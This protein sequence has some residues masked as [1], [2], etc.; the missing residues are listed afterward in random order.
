MKST[1]AFLKRD[2]KKNKK[3]REI[4]LITTDSFFRVSLK[5]LITCAGW[6]S[7]IEIDV[8]QREKAPTKRG[9]EKKAK[10][11]VTVFAMSRR[12]SRYRDEKEESLV[13]LT[14]R[15]RRWATEDCSSSLRLL[16][17]FFSI[18]QHCCYTF[19]SVIL[20][21]F[22]SRLSG[23]SLTSGQKNILV[24]LIQKHFLLFFNWS[25]RAMTTKRN[26][27]KQNKNT[28]SSS[29]NAHFSAKS[30]HVRRKEIT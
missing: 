19:R 21:S 8:V 20:F 3:K 15:R 2:K 16:F 30:F 1:T 28:N 14:L 26:K 10:D 18:P 27:T 17:F 12:L 29:I 25:T 6:R 5:V 9:H 22:L 13:E 4:N 11:C 23:V 24:F 7:L